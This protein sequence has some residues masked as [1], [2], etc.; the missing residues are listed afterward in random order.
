MTSTTENLKSQFPDLE[1]Y[2]LPAPQEHPQY[3]YDGFQPGVTILKKGHTCS[4]DR[5]AFETETIFERDVSITMRDGIKIYT[6]HN[7]LLS[8]PYWYWDP[9]SRGAKE[10]EEY[11]KRIDEQNY[12]RLTGLDTAYLTRV[13]RHATNCRSVFLDDRHQPWGAAIIKRETGLYPSSCIESDYSESYLKKAVHAVLAAMTASEVPITTFAINNG[14]ER[15]H[16]HPKMLLPPA[17]YLDHV[18]WV[19]TLSMLQLVLNPGYEDVPQV[20]SKPLGEFIMLFPKLE[21]LDLYFDT[22]VEQPNFNALAQAIHLP[23]LRILKLAG[24]NCLPEDLLMIFNNHRNTLREIS[25]NVVGISSMTGGSWETLLAKI[26]DRFQIT[27]FKM[28]QCDA[29][30]SDLCFE[31]YNVDRSFAI[32]LK[33]GDPRLLDRLI[34]GIKKGPTSHEARTFVLDTISMDNN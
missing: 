28:M 3:T 8:L 13:F 25:L 21:C 6:D 26:R 31:E 20:W 18:P 16:V 9:H 29:D 10:R 30:G 5:R 33:G 23:R 32:D 2:K 15:L 34:N 22:R 4:P 1:W 17:F 19:A 11:E 24:I 7:E 12:L 14:N 27:R